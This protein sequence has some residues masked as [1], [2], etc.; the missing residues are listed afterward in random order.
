MSFTS[1]LIIFKY[2]VISNFKLFSDCFVPFFPIPSLALFLC[3]LITFFN[4]MHRFIF[5]NVRVAT[6]SFALSDLYI[7]THVITVF[8]VS[9]SLITS[10]LPCVFLLP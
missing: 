8:Q 9:N 6:I 2:V 10:L 4:V 7:T 3:H 1:K 5:I